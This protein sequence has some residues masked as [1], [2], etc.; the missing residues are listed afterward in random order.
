MKKASIVGSNGNYFAE[1]ET[2]EALD[3]WI[4]DNKQK[5]TWGKKAGWYNEGVLTQAEKNTA[6]QTMV[7][8]DGSTLYMIPDQFA[9]TIEDNTVEVA[10]RDLRNKK[11]KRLQFGQNLI[12]EFTVSNDAISE[13]DTLSL[14]SNADVKSVKDLLGLGL[15]DS[16]KTVLQGMTPIADLLTQQQI[17]EMIL[18]IDNYVANE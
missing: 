1:F 8:E 10:A 9:V 12:F 13:S 11:M 4:Q 15:L 14:F 16:A 18:A 7:G 17:D 3:A 2:E 6:T 5:K